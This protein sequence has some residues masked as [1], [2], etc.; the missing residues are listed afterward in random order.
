MLLIL[1]QSFFVPVE[2]V[3]IDWSSFTELSDLLSSES[4]TIIKSLPIHRYW[5]VGK[6]RFR[7]GILPEYVRHE[8]PE[9]ISQ[10]DIRITRNKQLLTIKNV[11][12]VD[13]N[14]VLSHML[15]AIQYLA[16]QYSILSL[17]LQRLRQDQNFINGKV[18]KLFEALKQHN[19][20][21]AEMASLRDLEAYKTQFVISAID[22]EIETYAKEMENI[23]SRYKEILTV[24]SYSHENIKKA[25][26]FYLDKQAKSQRDKFQLLKQMS[27]DAAE[28]ER[29]TGEL[30]LLEDHNATI[31][32]LT[33]D[34]QR[35]ID[36]VKFRIAEQYRVDRENEHVRQNIRTTSSRLSQR[37]LERV[38]EV[39]FAEVRHQAAL[40]LGD[41]EVVFLWAGALLL[42][43][44][45]T[46]TMQELGK[47]LL[48]YILQRLAPA[49]P[50]LLRST[51]SKDLAAEQTHWTVDS[52]T[53]ASATRT[54]LK[55]LISKLE[56]AQQLG[57]VSDPAVPL[58]IVLLHGPAGCGKSVVATTVL[59]TLSR[60]N[61][62]VEGLV[63]TG[64]EL[65][66]GGS[67]GTA[68]LRELL[69]W[70]EGKGRQL[71]RRGGFLVLI[72]DNVDEALAGR[73]DGRRGANRQ[74]GSLPL[75][76]EALRHSSLNVSYIMTTE[77]PLSEVDL[78]IKDRVD[79]LLPLSRPSPGLRKLHLLREAA[80][81]LLRRGAVGEVRGSSRLATRD[82]SDDTLLDDQ[83]VDDLEAALRQ[84][85]ETFDD[86]NEVSSNGHSEGGSVRTESTSNGSL[87]R[88]VDKSRIRGT[89]ANGHREDSSG[90][91]TKASSVASK[92]SSCESVTAFLDSL[93]A[94][95][96]GWSYRALSQ[97]VLTLQTRAL[98]EDK[99]KL[100]EAILTAELHHAQ[101]QQRQ[102]H[103]DTNVLDVQVSYED[104]YTSSKKADVDYFSSS[105]PLNS[106]R[107]E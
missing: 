7:T 3:I 8:H 2:N 92:P 49:A 15:A 47:A 19:L 80:R 22:G 96:D 77:L 38:L 105:N 45:A 107:K 68:R 85:E 103:N 93:A 24:Q 6:A 28:T 51:K 89:A 18:N 27:L 72:L 70:A 21:A 30:S 91:G 60:S 58:P 75:L 99:C 41:V 100:T 5:D 14:I 16:H 4:I 62:Y 88:S 43:F 104:A 64:G 11:S 46:V 106:R 31:D 36:S 78:A 53:L 34:V 12:V 66:G 40:L 17:E 86:V 84:Y 76:L 35:V 56:L 67:L 98:G 50:L 44:F 65:S 29:S 74:H 39:V 26:Q 25:K 52:L 1:F 42:L 33:R 63:V 97:C 54:A 55:S 69:L 94:V 73:S 81:L 79:V 10:M 59:Q 95:S 9:F 32:A 71:R 13:Q 48:R 57:R 90:A 61:R 87:R 101:E 83:S 23:R 37:G 20:T 102:F 82:S